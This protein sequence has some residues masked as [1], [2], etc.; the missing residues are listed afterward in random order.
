MAVP[1]KPT[2]LFTQPFA[3]NGNFTIIPDEQ[4]T[5]GRASLNDGFPVETQLPL[6]SG[7]I[8]PNRLDFNGILNMLSAFACYAQAGGLWTYT[9][10]QDY[11]VPAMVILNNVLYISLQ[12][13]GPNTVVGIK[14]P[15]TEQ[16]Y[17]LRVGSGGGAPVGTVIMYWGTTAPEGYFAMNGQSFSASQYPELYALLGNSSN[18]PD[19][20][21][22]FCSW[23]W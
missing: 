16:E 12:E 23:I 13:N 17:W 22:F 10:E 5:T 21:G 20:R 9:E 11:P 1:N 8:P 3:N 6:S 2:N 14:S 4:A 15:E 7:G 19:M 18:V